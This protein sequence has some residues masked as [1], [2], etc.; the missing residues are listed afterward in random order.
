MLTRQKIFTF[1]FMET[2]FL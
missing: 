2:H 1:L